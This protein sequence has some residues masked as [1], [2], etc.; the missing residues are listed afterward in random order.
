MNGWMDVGGSTITILFLFSF[1]NGA[2]I[3]FLG[4]KKNK[5][6]EIF[7]KHTDVRVLDVLYEI[8]QTSKCDAAA[9]EFADVEQE[10]GHITDGR[11][12]TGVMA[13]TRCDAATL[14]PRR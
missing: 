7:V 2:R 1:S 11:W 9:I 14:G 13:K 5:S 12:L 4:T 10:Y 3:Q 8:A 6:L